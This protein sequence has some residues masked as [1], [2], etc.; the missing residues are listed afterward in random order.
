MAVFD[1][2]VVDTDQQSYQG[3][4]LEAILATHKASKKT[5]YLGAYH[6]DRKYFVP[7]VALVDRI[8]AKEHAAATKRL[9]VLLSQK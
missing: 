8:M 5:K 1:V 4:E 7:L 9:M 2:R 3:R 6:K